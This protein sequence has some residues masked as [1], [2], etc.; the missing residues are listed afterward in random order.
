MS[1]QNYRLWSP[2]FGTMIFLS[3]QIVSRSEN[4]QCNDRRLFFQ[5]TALFQVSTPSTPHHV[6]RAANSRAAGI[7]LKNYRAST[8]VRS[9]LDIQKV[10]EPITIHRLKIFKA[11]P[12]VPRNLCTDLIKFKPNPTVQRELAGPA[13]ASGGRR[14]LVGIYLSI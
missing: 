9:L 1:L 12:T 10:H 11:Y 7:C 14:G 8:H 3:K 2:D 5:S 13:I 4:I 6:D